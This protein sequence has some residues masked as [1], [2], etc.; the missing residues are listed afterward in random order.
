MDKDKKKKRITIKNISDINT[1][2]IGSE[3][4]VDIK[5]TTKIYTHNHYELEVQIH[6][7][8]DIGLIT[9][10]NTIQWVIDRESFNTIGEIENIPFVSETYHAHIQSGN[11]SE[12]IILDR[13]TLNDKNLLRGFIK[14]NSLD[15]E[16]RWGNNHTTNYHP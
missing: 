10:N 6:H 15:F 5:H 8:N 13:N 14:E 3:S 4:I 9:H 2:E 11:H 1:M 12:L 16:G 7:L